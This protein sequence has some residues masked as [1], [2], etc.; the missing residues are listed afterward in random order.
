ME[1]KGKM[2]SGEDLF[3]TALLLTVRDEL[4]AMKMQ[5]D[6]RLTELETTVKTL[7]IDIKKLVVLRTVETKGEGSEIKSSPP[8]PKKPE[9]VVT[10]AAEIEEMGGN[11]DYF[12]AKRGGYNNL[13]SQ[14]LRDLLEMGGESVNFLTFLV[15]KREYDIR[16]QVQQLQAEYQKLKGSQLQEHFREL[17]KSHYTLLK[18]KQVRTWKEEVF[19]SAFDAFIEWLQM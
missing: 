16:Q 17:W 7:A 9:H 12:I 10:T 6:H 1:Q 4:Q 19:L 2:A 15:Q 5:T 13:L 18:H 11:W 8:S 14:T 3:D